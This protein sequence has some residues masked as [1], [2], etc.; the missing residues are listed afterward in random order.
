MN[1]PIINKL[2]TLQICGFS[3][4]MNNID[5]VNIDD[6]LANYI[7][8]AKEAGFDDVLDLYN[9]QIGKLSTYDYD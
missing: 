9:Q 8:S 7:K 3:E 6:F 1:S 4:Y 5:S 2:L